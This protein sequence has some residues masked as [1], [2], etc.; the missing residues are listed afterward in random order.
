L[1]VELSDDGQNAWR[2]RIAFNQDNNQRPVLDEERVWKAGVTVLSRPDAEDRKDGERLTQTYLE[3]TFANRDFRDISEFFRSIQYSHLVPHLVRDPERSV[4]R[5]ADPYGGDFLE[6]LALDKN[7]KKLERIQNALKIA[8]PQ[9]TGL[10]VHRDNKGTPHLRGKYR[11][12]RPNGAWQNE[13]EFSDG[14]LRLIGLLWALQTGDGPLLLEEPELSL[15]SGVVRYIPVMMHNIQRQ[16]KKGARQIFISTH[17]DDLLS[18]ESIQAEEVF[19]LKAS[20]EGTTMQN[21]AEIDEIRWELDAGFRVGEAVL[22]RTMPA[23][24]VQMNLALLD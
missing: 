13:L 14:T 5:R 15:H 12:W 4:G 16:R 18:D 24:L 8:V 9:L 10:E 20:E 11:H 19:L 22:P 3:Q 1:D 21:A 6:Q 23:E 2:Y 7:K 17:S